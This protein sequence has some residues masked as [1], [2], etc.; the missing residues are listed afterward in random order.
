[1]NVTDY[2]IP[3]GYIGT[4]Q[5]SYFSHSILFLRE[6]KLLKQ[7][8]VSFRKKRSSFRKKKDNKLTSQPPVLLF[9]ML[10]KWTLIQ[11][12]K[13]QGQVFRKVDNVIRWIY[14][15]RYPVGMVYLLRFHRIVIYLSCG[16][17]KKLVR[18]SGAT[19]QLLLSSRCRKTLNDLLKINGRRNRRISCRIC[20]CDVAM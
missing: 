11:I 12:S 1:M 18:W 16:L 6:E 20:F 9:S 17:G 7:S 19:N 8:L 14:Q 2:I 4:F 3:K 10:C 5:Y 15:N 13:I